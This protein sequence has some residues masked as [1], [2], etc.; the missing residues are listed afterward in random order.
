MNLP[1]FVN[2]YQYFRKTA[3]FGH[4]AIPGHLGLIS[5]L[6]G[7]DENGRRI[8]RKL[9][10]DAEKGFFRHFLAAGESSDFTSAAKQPQV[11]PEWHWLLSGG[12]IA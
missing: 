10:W 3:S 2:L 7:H 11:A 8:G 4:L 1:T 6:T 12:F 9:K 5:L